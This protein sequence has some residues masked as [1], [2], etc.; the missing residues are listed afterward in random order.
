MVYSGE[1]YVDCSVSSV[2]MVVQAGV[3]PK[4]IND[5]Q[6]FLLEHFD[7]IQNTPSHIYHYAPC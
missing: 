3:E 4:W 5:S 6:H 7:T 1:Y 2:F